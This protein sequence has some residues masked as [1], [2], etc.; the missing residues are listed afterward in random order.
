MHAI[1]THL[2][3][4]E[5]AR[6]PHNPLRSVPV[7]PNRDGIVLDVGCGMGQTLS[8]LDFPYSHCYGIDV[9]AE[10]IHHGRQ[11]FP[12]MD[13]RVGSCESLD[14][15]SCHFNYVMSRVT[16]PYTDI[17]KCL[18]EIHRV[19]VPDGEIWLALHGSRMYRIE[20]WQNIRKFRIRALIRNFYVLLNSLLFHFTGRSYPW[21]AESRET[22]QTESRMR[23][24]LTHLG[25][26]IVKV[27]KSGRHFVIEARKST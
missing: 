18:A 1:E 13:L 20:L 14:F 17:P 8:V 24:I 3:A 22:F 16:L 5:T 15:P 2:K 7:F 27:Q 10:A 4:L 6:D 23:K 21:N 12:T 19:L 25:F 11:M 26:E 9:D